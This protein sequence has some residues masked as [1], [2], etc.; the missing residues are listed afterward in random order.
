MPPRSRLLAS[1]ACLS[2]TLS[3]SAGATGTGEVTL[4]TEE[5]VAEA[6]SSNLRLQSLDTQADIQAHRARSRQ[7]LDNP[8]LRV[9]NL[10]TR[11]RN[12]R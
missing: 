2:L 12:G 11:K 1:L 8:E 5:A 9:R 10:A 3:Q 6:L 7:W 4:T